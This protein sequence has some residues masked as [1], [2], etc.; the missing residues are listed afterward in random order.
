[1]KNLFD[2]LLQRQNGVSML[3]VLG[4]MALSVPLVTGLLSFSGTLSKD[5]RTKTAILQG[6]YSAQGCTQQ[7]TYKL[8]TDSSYV[9]GLTIGVPDVY[10][11]D[12]CTITVTQVSAASVSDVAYADLV[13]VLD[14]SWSI[15]DW[16]SPPTELDLL[17]QAANTIVDQFSLPT[18]EGRVRIGISRFNDAVPAFPVTDMTD[19]DDHGASELLHD[20]INSL[21]WCIWPP[22][23]YV[24]TNIVAGLNAG[25]AQY[26]TGLGDRVDPPYPVPNLMIFIT[27]GN[28][29]EGN[30]LPAIE[31]AS[32]ATGAEVFA[33]G[34]GSGVSSATLDAIA[35]DPNLTHVFDVDD[36]DELLDIIDSIVA[37]VLGSAGMGSVFT[38]ESVSPDGTVSISMYMIP[39]P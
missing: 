27:D 33:I 7:A 9:A 34:V 3:I 35:T 19:I 14:N 12:G 10:T 21:S 2:R 4:F 22:S 5:S 24:E 16:G 26:A 15:S 30:L 32:L 38:I 17:K 28:D 25:A 1:M 37:A 31:T 36:F 23:C 8:K 39:P 6:Q 20:G 29:N 11:F 13:I 18:T